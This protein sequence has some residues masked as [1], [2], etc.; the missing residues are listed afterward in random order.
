VRKVLWT[1]AGLFR[2][3]WP[4]SIRN[5]GRVWFPRSSLYPRKVQLFQTIAD[6]RLDRPFSFRDLKRCGPLIGSLK[7]GSTR[8][9][10]SSLILT[11]DYKG[12]LKRVRRERHRFPFHLWRSFSSHA[13]PDKES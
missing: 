8:G 2:K 9:S 6:P 4:R 10:L 7:R 3:R 5:H 13:V 1:V 11:G 12:F